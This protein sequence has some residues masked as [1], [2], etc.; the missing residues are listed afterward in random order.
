MLMIAKS[1]SNVIPTET[2]LIFFLTFNSSL[3]S[4]NGNGTKNRKRFNN[5]SKMFKS[6]LITTHC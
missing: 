6:S 2:T 5:R 1:V 4:V 3:L